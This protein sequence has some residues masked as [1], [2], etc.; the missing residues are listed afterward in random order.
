[1]GRV[2]SFGIKSGNLSLCLSNGVSPYHTFPLCLFLVVSI[3]PATGFHVCVFSSS[4]FCV[5]KGTQNEKTKRSPVRWKSLQ[6]KKLRDR[7]V[8][9]CF[10]QHPPLS[11]G[12]LCACFYQVLLSHAR[13]KWNL[14]KVCHKNRSYFLYKAENWIGVICSEIL[15]SLS[16]RINN[17]LHKLW[18]N[19]QKAESSKS[20]RGDYRLE[21]ESINK[22][23]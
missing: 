20:E 10:L 23:T 8:A 17:N 4:C 19:L 21:S 5:W 3:W 22:K 9:L 13:Y 18:L 7:G 16:F 14:C 1:M 12:Q 15:S 11:L 2:L 6:T